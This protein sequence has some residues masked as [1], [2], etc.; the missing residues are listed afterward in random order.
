MGGTEP[1]PPDDNYCA[2]APH[3]SHLQL[4][5]QLVAIEID[6][7]NRSG[8]LHKPSLFGS[9][10]TFGSSGFLRQ[11]FVRVLSPRVA[12]LGSNSIDV[13]AGFSRRT[14]PNSIS[15]QAIEYLSKLFS[16]SYLSL[17]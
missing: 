14:I 10:A 6:Y 8:D 17:A 7:W 16:S 11:M 3:P 4:L 15:G 5:A 12:Q 2:A 1:D 9:R 13:S